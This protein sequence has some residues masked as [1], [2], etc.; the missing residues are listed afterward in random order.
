MIAAI[1]AG[2]GS[3]RIGRDKLLLPV[4]GEPMIHRTIGALT[5]VFD[6]IVVIG[7]PRPYLE[8]LGLA[9]VLEDSIEGAGPI[10]GIYT[11][12]QYVEDEYAFFVACDMPFLD[13]GIIQQQA[14]WAQEGRWD[15]IVPRYGE[16][17]EPLHAVYSKRC[18]GPLSVL[19]ERGVYRIRRLYDRV[20]V[21]YLD[22]G[23]EA[24]FRTAFC[25]I[26]TTEVWQ[27]I[28]RSPAQFEPAHSAL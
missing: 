8:D 11:G 23:S 4:R 24:L 20:D 10:G 26:N 9:A 5:E 28:E 18:L 17:L 14:A 2:G 7:Q 12:L 1:L 19:I 22:I 15:A 25:N 21:R 3:S 27:E 16:L 6:R 13:V